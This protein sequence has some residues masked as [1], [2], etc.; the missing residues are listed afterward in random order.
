MFYVCIYNRNCVLVSQNWGR[1]IF[2]ILKNSI[3]LNLIN[4]KFLA[5]FLKIELLKF[6]CIWNEIV[7]KVKNKFLILSAIS[8]VVSKEYII[9]KNNT[10]IFKCYILK[11]LN[12]IRCKQCSF[13]DLVFLRL[14]W[15]YLNYSWT[16]IS[17]NLCSLPLKPH[18]YH[19]SKWKP[20]TSRNNQYF[21]YKMF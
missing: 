21:S 14:F 6:H 1:K 16:S 18:Y 10:R 2:F 7:S 12:L 13:K 19:I 3:S 8:F 17:R 9:G 5:F 20:S 15:Y 11:H 4:S